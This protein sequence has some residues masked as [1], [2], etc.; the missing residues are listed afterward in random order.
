MDNLIF[1]RALQTFTAKAVFPA[2]FFQ[3][4]IKHGALNCKKYH[5]IV[6]LT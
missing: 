3:F 1:M 6:K 5:L 2:L 4:S